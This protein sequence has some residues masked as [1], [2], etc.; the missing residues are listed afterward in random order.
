MAKANGLVIV[1]EDTD[2]VFEGD[3]VKV[4]MLDWREE[5]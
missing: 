2:G 5:E 1:T 4:H 3:T